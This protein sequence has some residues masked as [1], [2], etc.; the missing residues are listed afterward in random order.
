ML[1]I[2]V[3]SSDPTKL[4]PPRLII[5]YSTKAVDVASIDAAKMLFKV[6][7]SMTTENFW[8]S[9]QILIGFVAAFAV[10]V[11]GVK[12]NN[13][14]SRQQQNPPNN[15]D[16]SLT[17]MNFVMQAFVVLCHVFVLLFFPFVVAVCLYW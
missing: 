14:Q 6:D 15:Q 9:L 11:Y 13:W 8:E 7:Y 1:S 2:Q 10:V 5:E 17:S 12:M 3:Q 16:E 4:A